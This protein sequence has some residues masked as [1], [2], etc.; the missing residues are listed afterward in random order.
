MHPPFILH[1]STNQPGFFEDKK[2]DAKARGEVPKTEK[3]LAKVRLV[4]QG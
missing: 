2:A 1:P 3:D 4:K